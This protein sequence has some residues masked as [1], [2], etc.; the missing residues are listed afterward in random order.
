MPYRLANLTPDQMM[1]LE[2]LEN[3]LGVTLIAYDEAERG[4]A[5]DPGFHEVHSSI[6][7]ALNDD[8]RSMHS[9][10]YPDLLGP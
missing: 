5:T 6:L 4:S 8:Y 10:P 9:A 7:D 1:R 3:E 2:N